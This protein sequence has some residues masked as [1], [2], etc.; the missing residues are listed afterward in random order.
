MPA[1]EP[2]ISAKN[3]IYPQ[4]TL[5]YPQKNPTYP[6]FHTAH[7]QKSPIYPQKNPEKRVT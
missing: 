1:K 5:T 2:Y 7:P 4:M 6:P 3:P